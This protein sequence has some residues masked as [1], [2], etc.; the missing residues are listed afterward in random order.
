MASLPSASSPTVWYVPSLVFPPQLRSSSSS[1]TRDMRSRS[2]QIPG[3]LGTSANLFLDTVEWSFDWTFPPSWLQW[4]AYSPL[5]LPPHTFEDRVLL[6]GNI[7]TSEQW[8]ALFTGRSRGGGMWAGNHLKGHLILTVSPLDEVSSMHPSS[9]LLYLT[10]LTN[11]RI[12]SL[13]TY[14]GRGTSSSI[15]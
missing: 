11:N 13:L 7:S 5:S 4:R 10:S 6:G 1:L 9:Q 12:H 14:L 2:A 3:A 8:D 15:N